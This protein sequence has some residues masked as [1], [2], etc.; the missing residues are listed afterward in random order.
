MIVSE[1]NLSNNLYIQPPELFAPARV[2]KGLAFTVL[3]SKSKNV[4][5]KI[6]PLKGFKDPLKLA[7]KC[8]P[9]MYDCL[10]YFVTCR[11]TI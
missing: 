3:T 4:F 5:M 6:K 8:H 10:D 2:G 9:Q 11:F 7:K 1:A